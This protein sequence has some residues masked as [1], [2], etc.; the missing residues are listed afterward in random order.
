M[1]KITIT[2]DNVFFE[3]F[4]EFCEKY[5]GFPFSELSKEE[6]SQLMREYKNSFR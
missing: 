3:V 5:C 2:Y 6:K 1:E 4:K